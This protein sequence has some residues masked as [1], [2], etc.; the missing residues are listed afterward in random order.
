MFPGYKQGYKVK[1]VI[2]LLIGGVRMEIKKVKTK[3]FFILFPRKFIKSYLINEGFEVYLATEGER[4]LE[5]FKNFD[6]DLV[7]V[8]GGKDSKIGANGWVIPG[9]QGDWKRTSGDLTIEVN[10]L[11]LRSLAPIFAMGRI[12]VKASGNISGNVEG[13]IKKKRIGGSSVS[14]YLGPQRFFS[15]VAERTSRPGVATGLAWTP[16]GGDILFIEASKMKG[17][18][19]MNLTGKLGDVMKESAS[20]ARSYLRANSDQFKIESDF[21]EK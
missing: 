17:K 14:K 7:V 6:I 11:E 13:K 5:L 15:E 21:Y 20:A 16:V 10:E 9:R 18:G 3:S 12:K 4:A 2:K 1:E 19:N 8:D